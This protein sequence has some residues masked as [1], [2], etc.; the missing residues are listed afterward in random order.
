MISDYFEQIK[1][2]T[3]A[4]IE[5]FLSTNS[6]N[7]KEINKP[8]TEILKRKGKRLRPILTQLT[9]DSFTKEKNDISK[10]II[11]P[12][13]IHNATLI[14]DD[15]EDSS[16]YR[17][18][19]KAIHKIHGMPISINSSNLFYFL[20]QK[21]I[22]NSKLKKKKKLKIL[23][24][25]NKTLT[26]L[27]I[28][29]GKDI[30][31]TEKNS[32]KISIKEYLNMCSLKTGELISFSLKLGAILANKE[33]RLKE[34][35]ILGR[36]IGVAFQIKDDILNLKEDSLGKTF[37]E[38]ITEGKKTFIIIYALDKANKK[39]KEK[40]TKILNSK[41]KD[42]N[43]IKKA[44]NILNKYEAINEATKFSNF[45]IKKSKRKINNIIK[46]KKQRKL[47]LELLH[48]LEKR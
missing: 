32:Q 19:K 35:E 10:F 16:E 18:N 37:S 39:D 33:K 25:L 13:L 7:L 2:K 30:Y 43:E 31:F 11:I 47:F 44:I 41:T 38:D 40:L 27:H 9:Y 5:Q 26:K 1:V 29:Q 24:E 23:S 22:Y 36:D 17:R 42:K 14:I 46:N 15:I 34:L 20:P 6:K 48:F 12:E 45:L 28:G 4:L 21:I 3:E 8:I